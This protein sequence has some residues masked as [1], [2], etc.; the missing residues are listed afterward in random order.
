MNVDEIL[1]AASSDFFWVPHDVH[2][3]DRDV[4]TYTYSS[5]PEDNYNRVTRVRPECADLGELVEEVVGRHRGSCSEWTLTPMSD[6]PELRETLREAGYELGFT[7]H[8]YAIRPDAYRR[9]CSDDVQVREVSTLDEL[10]T[11]YEIWDDVFGG[12]PELTD[13]ELAGELEDCTGDDRRVARFVAYRN[14]EPAGSGGLTFF[15]ELSF[16]LIWA[17][18]V[19]KAHRGNGVYTSLLQARADAAAN[20]GLDRMGLYARESTSAP[21]VEAHGFERYGPMVHFDRDLRDL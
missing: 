15:D 8:A 10:R 13:E 12:K 18:G 9:D 3:V 19:R 1:E 7:L 20:R 4:I 14:G 16:G 2:V 6:S 17:G 21:I 11:V 5:R